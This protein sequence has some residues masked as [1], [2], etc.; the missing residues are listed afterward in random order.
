MLYTK[1]ILPAMFIVFS[2]KGC[3]NYASKVSGTLITPSESAAVKH[4]IEF[5]LHRFKEK[6]QLSQQ[7]FNL[8]NLLERGI[9]YHHSGLLPMLKEIV[10]I[11]FSKGFIKVIFTTETLAIGLNLPV[12]TV[13]FT[14]YR[15][16]DDSTGSKRML[17]TDEYT[18]ICGRAG[19][20]GKDTKGYV[21]YLPE[22]EY[23]DLELVKKM[24]CGSKTKL[25]SRMK[26]EYE[27]ILKTVHNKNLNWVD[28]VEHSYFFEQVKKEIHSMENEKNEVQKKLSFIQLNI[29]DIDECNEETEL[30]QLLKQSTNA[31]FRKVQARYEQWKMKHPDRIM[32]PIR[33]KYNEYKKLSEEIKGLEEDLT[34]YG[35]YNSSIEPYFKVL[36]E[37]DFMNEDRTLTQKGV[38]ATEINEGN[39]LLISELY[40]QKQFDSLSLQ[41][42]LQLLSCFLEKESKEEIGSSGTSL[43]NKAELFCKTIMAVE[44]KYKIAF[45]N[46]EL[47]YEYINVIKDLFDNRSIQE[48]CSKYEMFEGNLTRLFLKLLNMIDELKSIALL[49]KNI[50]LLEKLETIKDTSIYTIVSP[51]SLYLYI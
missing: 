23:E 44:K 16:Y 25:T 21:F 15:K 46:W 17:Y 4:I 6:V 38:N 26:F 7:Y 39:A 37:L 14:S 42:V 2:R 24:M 18:Q 40:E 43:T 36:T 8:I 1:D 47:N 29:Q 41:E 50:D 34:C 12:R 45:R 31:Q 22:H 5:H 20:R 48:I 33:K 11:L 35:D 13:V 32:D 9:A 10:E 30:K 19:R 27:F 51:D 49:N 28:L 3:E